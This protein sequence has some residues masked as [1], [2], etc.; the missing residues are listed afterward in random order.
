[1]KIYSRYGANSHT[2]DLS[3]AEDYFQ[4]RS[5]LKNLISVDYFT[6]LE[7]AAILYE[8]KFGRWFEDEENRIKNE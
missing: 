7:E 6:L 3:H 1:M 5:R 2:T 8:E 4:L